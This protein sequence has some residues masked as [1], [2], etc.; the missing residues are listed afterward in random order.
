MIA[1]QAMTSIDWQMSCIGQLLK[2]DCR[3]GNDRSCC[4]PEVQ[5]SLGNGRLPPDT[6]RL[7]GPNISKYLTARI[8]SKAEVHKIVLN[9]RNVLFSAV[10]RLKQTGRHRLVCG[11]SPAVSLLLVKDVYWCT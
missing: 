8:H 6:F 9:F 10:R 2:Y 11:N 3:T 5:M 4:I 7:V 1:P